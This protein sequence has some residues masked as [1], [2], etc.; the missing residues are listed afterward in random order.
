VEELVAQ[1]KPYFFDELAYDP[2]SVQKH[3]LKNRQ[4]ALAR[5]ELLTERLSATAWEPESLEDAVRG[6]A[7]ELGVGAGKVIHPLR[8]ALT[9]VAASPGIFDL[10]M[11]LG[12][13]RSLRRLRRAVAVLSSGDPLGHG[14]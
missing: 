3:W 4:E 1:A 10:L 11:L 5:L 7:E 6:L 9:G 8:V 12:R 13:N 2:D 14:A